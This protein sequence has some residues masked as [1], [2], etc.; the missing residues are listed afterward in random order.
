VRQ[1]ILNATKFH[2]AMIQAARGL[3]ADEIVASVNET[4][5]SEVQFAESSPSPC[6]QVGTGLRD[7]LADHFSTGRRILARNRWITSALGPD[8]SHV[9]GQ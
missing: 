6:R 9:G 3:T 2:G 7:L 4:S 1:L 5:P 8:V